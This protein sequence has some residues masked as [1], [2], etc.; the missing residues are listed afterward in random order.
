TAGALE[1][2]FNAVRINIA[3][4]FKIMQGN[5]IVSN[6]QTAILSQ[7]EVNTRNLH[8]MKKDL[9]EMNSKIKPGLA[10]IP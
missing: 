4:I 10:G 9:S 2:Q 8:Q 7:I 5:Q 1:G 6:A 3:A